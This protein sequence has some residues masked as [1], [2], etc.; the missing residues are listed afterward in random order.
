MDL[1]QRLM[2]R[3]AAVGILVLAMAAAGCGS[4]SDQSST[5]VIDGVTVIKPGTL[6]AEQAA[7][8]GHTPPPGA[9][10]AYMKGLPSAPTGAPSAAAA[11]AAM[12]PGQ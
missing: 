10:A 2:S 11:A 4:R 8:Q 5:Q 12:H 6:A 9:V 1:K 3:L 7:M